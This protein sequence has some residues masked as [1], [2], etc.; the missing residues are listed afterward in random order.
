[1]FF[2]VAPEAAAAVTAAADDNDIDWEVII[3]ELMKKVEEGK[4]TP[5]EL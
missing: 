2:R 3:A 5:P 1:L 4:V